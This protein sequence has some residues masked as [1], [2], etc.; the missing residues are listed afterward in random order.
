MGRF[1]DTMTRR[2]KVS[3]KRKSIA[4]KEIELKR[5]LAEIFRLRKAVQEAERATEFRH[6]SLER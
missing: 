5:L 2:V 4:S 3:K 1:M 6:A